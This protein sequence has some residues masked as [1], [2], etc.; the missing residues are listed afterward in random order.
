MALFET[1]AAKRAHRTDQRDAGIQYRMWSQINNGIRDIET[2]AAN[3]NGTDRVSIEKFF[4]YTNTVPDYIT[5]G[6]RDEVVKAILLDGGDASVVTDIYALIVH[7]PKS[8]YAKITACQELLRRAALRILALEDLKEKAL[9]EIERHESNV[10][11]RSRKRWTSEDDDLLIETAAQDG[12]TIFGMAKEFG[13]TPSA[14]ASRI[15]HLVGIKRM[16][17]EV[18]GRFIGTL[19]G[20]FVEGDIDGV[21]SKS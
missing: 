17:A 2:V 9:L 16:S 7:P 15:S 11:E 8:A 4:G 1:R 6:K 5:L 19:N 14:I 13:R 12:A 20:E 10:G 21:V 3:R 18:A